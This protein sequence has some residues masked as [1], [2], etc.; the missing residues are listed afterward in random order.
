MNDPVQAEEFKKTDPVLR[1]FYDAVCPQLPKVQG[2]NGNAQR[3]VIVVPSRQDGKDIP[4]RV[5]SNPKTVENPSLNDAP[6]TI[7]SQRDLPSKVTATEHS[8]RE[9]VEINI[10]A[11][12][13]AKVAG[14]VLNQTRS[15]FET[16]EQK[17][18][19][20]PKV[21]PD[22]STKHRTE[23]VRIEFLDRTVAAKAPRPI[24]VE[25]SPK[26]QASGTGI[27]TEVTRSTFLRR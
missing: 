10:P 25:S 14:S 3:N 26:P 22:S 18:P 5:D 8:P 12:P 23:V 24:A 17:A 16:V 21:Q 9:S 4:V 27:K 13:E 15:V 2:T 7:T 19:G 6:S 1:E 11:K 20:T